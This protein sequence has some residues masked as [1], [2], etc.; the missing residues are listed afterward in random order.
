LL[1]RTK[2]GK[3]TYTEIISRK[4]MDSMSVDALMEKLFKI[5]S[6]RKKFTH[7]IIKPVIQ[8]GKIYERLKSNFSLL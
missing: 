3:Y 8:G 2:K 7:L 4:L 5:V 6:S 1:K